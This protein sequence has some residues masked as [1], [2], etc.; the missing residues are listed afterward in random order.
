MCESSIAVLGLASVPPGSA[1]P[2]SGPSRAVFAYLHEREGREGRELARAGSI[3]EAAERSCGFGAG[4]AS[5][6]EGLSSLVRGGS[7]QWWTR[8]RGAREDRRLPFLSSV[9]IFTFVPLGGV[10]LQQ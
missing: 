1:F 8:G 3:A 2:R 4:R 10:S 5:A 6:R 9:K 7:S